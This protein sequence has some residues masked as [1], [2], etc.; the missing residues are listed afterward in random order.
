MLAATV[1]LSGC[2]NFFQ[3]AK[4]SCTNS[5]T[6]TTT[7]SGDY[8]YVSNSASGASYL[9]GYSIGSGALTVI[10][11]FPFSLGF[12]P[13]AMKVSPNN[14][15]L[16][17]GS[18]GGGIYLYTISSSGAL[19]ASGSSPVVTTGTGSLSSV[20][21]S[22]DG[23]F[24]YAMDATGVLLYQYTL[25]TST[26]A[27]TGT[28]SF[29]V[30]GTGGCTASGL[31]G[32]PISQSCTVAVSPLSNGTGY[33][34]VALGTAGTVVY[35]YTTSGGM[36]Q[37]TVGVISPLA[38]SGDFSLAFDSNDYLYIARTAALSSYVSVSSSSPTF[39]GSVTYAN[40]SVIP[41]AVTLSKGYSY[42][43][44]ADEG[45]STISGFSLSGL[46]QASSLSGSQYAAPT[47]VSALGVD[48]TG[49][50]LIAVGYNASTGVQLFKPSSGVLGSAVASAGTGTS[51]GT[52]ALVAL[53]H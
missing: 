38:S 40:N 49:T 48:N 11:G 26:G 47:N 52:P 29:G 17:V 41:R 13:V 28:T 7:N 1:G 34:A 25:N 51:L 46:A 31:T 43:Y 4:S 16:Y 12:T 18:A 22:P 45:A 53:T 20:D 21:I 30:P 32:E 50:Y 19:T 3:C 6:T 33:V 5:T 23:D 39:E 24:L 9:S 15:F 35:P 37:A 27:I 8:A 14:S 10:S 2:Q 42:L 44:T 36:S